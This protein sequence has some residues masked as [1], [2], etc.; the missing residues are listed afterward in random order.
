MLSIA[1]S[2]ALL[3]KRFS[4]SCAIP[5]GIKKCTIMKLTAILLTI[6]CLNAG[7]TTTGQ[8][9]TLREKNTPL[10]KVFQSITKQTGYVFF[11]AD[12]LLDKTGNVSVEAINTTLEQALNL[13]LEGKGLAW[14]IVDKTIVIKEKPATPA[15]EKPLL[16]VVTGKV[17]NGQAEP[18]FGASVSEKGTNN[19]TMTKNDGTFSIDVSRSN[20]TLVVSYIGY[21][22]KELKLSGQAQLSITL[23]SAKTSLDEVVII[24]YGAV[25]KRDLTGAVVSLKGEEL[26]E[27]PSTNVL[28]AAQGKIAGADIVRSSGQAGAGVSIQI[29]GVRSVAGG[30]NQPLIIVDGIQYQRIEDINPNDIQ[31]MEILKDASS[32]A[33][34]GSRA[35]NGVIL[36]TTKKG[37][38][39]RTEVTFNSYVGTSQATMYPKAMNFDEFTAMRREAYRAAG[40]WN[41]AADDPVAFAGNGEL[42]AVQK[43]IWTDYQEALIRPGLQQDYQLGLRGGSD[44]LKAYMSLDYF[45]ERGILRMDD[46][47]RYTGRLNLDFTVNKWMTVGMQSQYTYY[48]QSIRRDPLNQANKVSP[49][50]ALYD[51]LG[52]FNFLLIDGQTGSPL[53]D[54]QPNVYKNAVQNT[55]V[56]ANAYLELRPMPGLTFRSTFGASTSNGR[57]GIYASPK[58]LDRGLQ[59]KS[60]SSYSMSN[61]RNLN[62]ENVLTWIK[63]FG[64]HS[65]TATGVASYVGFQ[66]EEATATGVNQLLPSQ[67]FYALEN[68]SEEIKISS[69]FLKSDLVS[70]AGRINYG[71]KNKYLLTL[72]GRTDGSSKLAQ[73][74]KWT[75]FP[76]AAFAWRII[77]ESFM[78]TVG[79]L[80]DLKLRLSYGVAGNDPGNAFIYSTQ[81][82]LQR[83]AFGWDNVAAQAYTYSRSVGNTA[84]GWELTTSKNIGLDFGILNNRITGS[85]EV[86][87]AETDDLLLT[88]GL[89]PTTGVTTVVQNIGKTRNRGIEIT[90]ATTNIQTSQFTWTSN[91]TFTH[92]KEEF[93][94]LVTGKDDIG[95][96]WFI[97]HPINVYYDYAK[98]GIWQTKDAA[99]AAKY[100]QKPGEIRVKD[101]NT[102]GS[103][104]TQNDRVILGTPRPKWSGGFDNTIR[105]KGFDLNIFVFARMGQMINADRYGRFDAQ[106]LGNSTSGI[107]YWTPENPSNDYPR[108]NKNSN[109]LYLSTLPYRDGSYLRLRNISLGYTV[110]SHLLKNSFVSGIRAYVT[111]K[112]LYTWTK[113]NLDYDPERGGSENFPMTKLFVFG[114]NINF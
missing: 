10:E 12:G 51:S 104:D 80:S 47:K 89:P 70:F 81:S 37:S 55:R 64:D 82:Q 78:K 66:S 83:L 9:V 85:V 106:G 72:T 105:Y 24:G 6:A 99:E 52:N 36:I 19:N 94:E 38:S 49:L 112:N 53:A 4:L 57:N 73:G 100:K 35:A 14:S 67:L 90:L 91:I 29:R 109:L 40:L 25:R 48:N 45:N 20:A 87:D 98:I 7:A 58:S 86:Y 102:D 56:L 34:Y 96:G 16:Q 97:G 84:L 75:F 31:S 44:K 59:G 2:K 111:A 3:T 93:V 92:N 11:Y 71:W 69:D 1:C 22:T 28:E 15:P 46:L 21:Q 23:D 108:P 8:T 61:G 39:G 107:N 18:L 13:C 17:V 114:L 5:E 79:A 63:N 54:Q 62:W 33:I 50:G 103:I 68:N 43:R 65:L 88:R 110:P 76:S 41:S 101:Q 113:A 30:S 77:D 32:T 27:V 60:Q 74:H 26:K 95:N 42:N